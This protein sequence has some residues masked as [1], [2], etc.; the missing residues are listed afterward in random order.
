MIHSALEEHET[1]AAHALTEVENL[2]FESGVS[3][4]FRKVDEANDKRIRQD[5]YFIG[6]YRRAFLLSRVT[7]TFCNRD[8]DNSDRNDD[9]IEH[10]LNGIR[11]HL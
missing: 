1:H 11:S 9:S 6:M 7:I 8:D 2:V 10:E 3:L 5:G 4:H